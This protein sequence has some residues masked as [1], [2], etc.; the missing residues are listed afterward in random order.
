VTRI[1]CPVI[2]PHPPSLTTCPIR[3]NVEKYSRA[4]RV[5]DDNI[6]CRRRFSCLIT[7]ATDTDSE[8]LVLF[9]GN[10]SYANAPQ[11]YVC[12]Y[13]AC[14]VNLLIYVPTNSTV[15]TGLHY[16]LSE[17][18]RCGTRCM[19]ARFF[20]S[21]SDNTRKLTGHMFWVTYFRIKFNDDFSDLIILLSLCF[22][23]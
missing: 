13:I 20:K 5:R 18:A 3:D 19:S 17:Q 16:I 6:V 14:L 15:P 22:S 12:M 9:H 2:P 11:Y 4:R 10:S 7:K 23:T 21:R 8:Y 1:L